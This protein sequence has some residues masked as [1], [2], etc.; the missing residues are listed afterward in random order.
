MGKGINYDS[1]VGGNSGRSPYWVQDS[2][3]KYLDKEG[4]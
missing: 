4:S 2:K 1:M 3:G